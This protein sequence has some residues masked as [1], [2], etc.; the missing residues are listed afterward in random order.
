MNS[1]RSRLQRLG[2]QNGMTWC[3]QYLSFKAQE[4]AVSSG[5]EKEDE[6]KGA[7]DDVRRQLAVFA[8]KSGYETIL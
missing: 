2:K 6:V 5:L 4:R 1:A 7:L 3:V 8:T